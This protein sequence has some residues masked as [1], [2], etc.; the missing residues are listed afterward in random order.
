MKI[1]SS[2]V[3][4]SFRCF[5]ALALAALLFASPR[6]DAGGGSF[7][8]QFVATE[9]ACPPAV[10]FQAL[11]NGQ[12]AA[13]GHA[14]VLPLGMDA[15]NPGGVVAGA[16]FTWTAQG[17]YLNY[18]GGGTPHEVLDPAG[19]PVTDVRGAT[20][21]ASAF[22]VLIN[23]PAGS[24]AA[25]T[26]HSG[27]Y[28]WNAGHVYLLLVGGTPT[29]YEVTFAGSPIAGT[30]GIARLA[31]QVIDS[32]EGPG[33]NALLLSGAVIYTDTRAIRARTHSAISTEEIQLGGASIASVRGV[34]AMGGSANLIALDA[35][36]FL[37][38]PTRVVLH[39]AGASSTTA[40]MLFS[41]ASISGTWGMVRQTRAWNGM[42]AYVGAAGL[43]TASKELFVLTSGATTVAEVLR[44]NGTSFVSSVAVAANHAMLRQAGGLMEVFA[45]YAPAGG[46]SVR[47]T[48]IGLGQ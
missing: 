28:F 41:G 37:W 42:G 15:F 46:G 24:I 2:A 29:T 22:D 36:C 44:P 7:V 3:R 25:V 47:G 8:H 10:W 27:L 45:V 32:D 31:A 43:M 14:G 6:A 13:L 16:W 23:V 35:A 34:L 33:V 21:L 19:N 9:T 4:P 5:P 38:T 30:R 18:Y 12:P 20:F 17:A 39:V 1:R 11:D 40:E 48:V 26:L